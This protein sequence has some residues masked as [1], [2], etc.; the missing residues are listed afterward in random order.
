MKKSFFQYAVV[1]LPIIGLIAVGASYL[2]RYSVILPNFYLV[3]E[4]NAVK[5]VR[6]CS[7]ALMREA[8]HM[9]NQAGDWSLWDDTYAYVVD[10]N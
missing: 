3:E 9:Q 6:R 4:Q 10:R 5:D 7:D 1:A 8:E 2:I